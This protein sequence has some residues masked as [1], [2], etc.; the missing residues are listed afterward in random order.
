MLHKLRFGIR[1]A[2]LII[3]E[4]TVTTKGLSASQVAKRYGISRQT[5]WAFM[6]RVRSS[7][8]SSKEHPL[9]GQVQ[10]DEFVFG[11]KEKLKQGR[12]T[13]S[14]KKKIVGGMLIS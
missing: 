5:A 7:M 12:S 3:F 14:K 10:D 6:H 11:G 13:D 4:M 9:K 1:K 8:Q 2:F